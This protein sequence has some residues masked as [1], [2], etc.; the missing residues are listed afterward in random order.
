MSDM[1]AFQDSIFSADPE[2][3][4]SVE[5]LSQIQI[6]EPEEALITQGDGGDDVYFVLS[7]RVRVSVYSKDGAE[8][9]LDLLKPGA[10]FGEMSALGLGRRTATV[11]AETDVRLR[12]FTKEAFLDLLA[13]HGAVGVRLSQL[14][15]QRVAK[16][17]ERMF[18]VSAYSMPGRVL[19][20]LIRHS[21]PMPGR[22]GERVID[23]APKTVEVARRV[24]THR[25][26]VSRSI[27]H[28]IDRG[29]LRREGKA[30]V[31]QHPSLDPAE[32]DDKRKD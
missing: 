15:A 28:L 3:M 23:P 5:V 17:S 14:L 20:D 7:G 21:S 11:T 19:A 12:V 24:L 18:E 29:H 6:A 25:E 4:A 22:S 32:I 2:I 9:W 8:I 1:I 30:L 13:R 26:T 10:V 27:K 31:L 16:T